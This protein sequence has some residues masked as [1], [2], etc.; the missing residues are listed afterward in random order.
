MYTKYLTSLF[1]L[2]Y[3]GYISHIKKFRKHD[4]SYSSICMYHNELD[5]P[6]T[7]GYVILS[8]FYQDK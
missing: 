1:T 6:P 8:T 4:L 3:I 5:H 2:Q 7:I